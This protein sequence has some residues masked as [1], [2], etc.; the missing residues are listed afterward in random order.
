[1]TRSV[2][3]EP[4]DQPLRED[5][6]LLGKLVG[7]MLSDQLGSSF[8]QLLE[9]VRRCAIARREG[10]A[11]R[12]GELS[13]LLGDL[14]VDRAVDLVRAFSSY[15]Q[16]VNL[17]E[18]V[19]R[20]RRRRE[21]QAADSGP[22]P[23]GVMDGL[24][25]LRD[26]GVS[27]DAV[28]EALGK[29]LLEPV[30]TAH[31]TEATR[32]TMLEK[33][34]RI[35][36][37]LIDRLDSSRTPEEE[38]TR[39]AQMRMHITAAWQTAE[40][41]PVRPSVEQ[42]REH[43]L[44]YLSDVLFRAV[45]ACYAEFERCLAA[46][47]PKLVT[48][49]PMRPLLR[50]GTWVGGDMDGNPNVGADT[51]REALAAHRR[52]LFGRYLGELRELSLILSQSRTRVAVDPALERRVVEYLGTCAGPGAAFLASSRHALSLPAD[53]DGRAADLESG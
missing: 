49:A 3:F 45:P 38:R 53:P 20:I 48:G 40:Y 10:E 2:V 21:H 50:F 8:F 31:P 42:E 23:G 12:L 47:Y 27:T 51:I 5:V 41:S 25:R 26:A 39:L 30:F 6:S 32:R 1:M 46:T 24:T 9:Q 36:R 33:E 35:V 19:H 16:L 13:S 4:Q 37:A 15:F 29:L 14:P 22:Q 18:Q 28:R 34:Q 52:V 17:A 44:F 7:E 11:D 43:V